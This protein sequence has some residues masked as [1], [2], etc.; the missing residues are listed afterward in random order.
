M[1][2]MPTT[3][4]EPRYPAVCDGCGQATTTRFV[5]DGKRPVFCP[6]CLRK[7]RSEQGR[8]QQL[9]QKAP[10]QLAGQLDNPEA[11]GSVSLNQ[12]K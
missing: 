1:P 12:L 5:P 9:A 6:E 11:G 2:S 8:Q 4:A 10:S 3:P 7:Y